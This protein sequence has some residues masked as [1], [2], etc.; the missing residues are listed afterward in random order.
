MDMGDERKM[1]LSRLSMDTI[2]SDY[3]SSAPVNFKSVNEL[4]L[5]GFD[6]LSLK[7]AG[8]SDVD[9]LTGGFKAA[10]LKQAGFTTETMRQ[11]GLTD[12]AIRVVGY[13]EEQ[14]IDVLLDLYYETGGS[15]HWK[16]SGGWNALVSQI[17]LDRLNASS[18]KVGINYRPRSQKLLLGSL[19][20]VH[21]E[22]DSG[23]VVI[24]ALPGNGL[25]GNC[26]LAKKYN[27]SNF[28]SIVGPL[29][30]TIGS[31]TSL[32]QLVLSENH[33]KGIKRNNLY[34]HFI[35]L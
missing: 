22:V 5:L 20:G 19:F 27:S 30:D 3:Q 31:L 33:L 13:R 29:L 1:S 2:D 8:F 21:Y 11:I 23:N 25:K 24:V 12:N 14:Q 9:I 32:T 17:E 28:V 6:P 26:R 10:E 15:L 16:Q 7:A 34:N 4:R 35:L 18:D